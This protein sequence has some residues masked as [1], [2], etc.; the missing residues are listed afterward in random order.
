MGGMSTKAPEWLAQLAPAHAPPPLGWW[1]PAP[2]WWGLAAL[3]LVAIAVLV[4]RWSDPALRLRRHAGKALRAIEQDAALEPAAR[5]RAL[6]DLLR[7]YAVARCGRAEV[8]RLSGEAW[9]AFLAARGGAAFAGEAGR[10]MLR[11]CYGGQGAF[12]AAA[13]FPAAK[14]F[15]KRAGRKPRGA[16]ASGEPASGALRDVAPAGPGRGAPLAPA[17]PATGVAVANA[18][19]DVDEAG[20]RFSAPESR[21]DAAAEPRVGAVDSVPSVR[22]GA[23]AP[24]VP[25][26]G[27][28]QA[29]AEACAGGP[30][31]DALGALP[32]RQAAAPAP[33]EDKDRSGPGTRAQAPSASAAPGPA[34]SGEGAR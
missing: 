4:W 21:L 13:L 28:A 9:L 26:A 23:L 25:A 33:A 18:A 12:D 6:E 14:S 34:A 11:L 29:N 16:G 3:L 27:P 24:S 20:T 19:P 17:V 22:D 30:L 2:G 7:R 5:A 8:A 1:P 15:L 31:A 10:G 32:G